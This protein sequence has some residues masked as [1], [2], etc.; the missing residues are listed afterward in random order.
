MNVRV[1]QGSLLGSTLFLLY[2]NYLSKN[3]RQSFVNINA[4]DT[5]VHGY[6]PPKYL[7]DKNLEAGLTAHCMWELGTGWSH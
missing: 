7:D 6:T 1:H 4:D 3:I 5:T 2:I